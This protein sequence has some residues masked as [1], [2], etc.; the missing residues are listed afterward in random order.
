MAQLND[1]LEGTVTDL[2]R[3]E[4]RFFTAYERL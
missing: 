2:Q 4:P 3:K 1:I